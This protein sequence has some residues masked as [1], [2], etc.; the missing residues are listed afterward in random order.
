MPL[1]PRRFPRALQLAELELALAALEELEA[2]DHTIGRQW[3]QARTR[4]V[5]AV[6]AERRY[7]QEVD[8]RNDWSPHQ[9]LNGVLECGVA[10]ILRNS[11]QQPQSF[12]ASMREL[13]PLS[14]K[15]SPRPGQKRFPQLWHAQRR[16]AA[17]EIAGE[18]VA[19]AHWRHYRPMSAPKQLLVHIRWQGNACTDLILTL[20][21][22]IK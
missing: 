8:L 19:A 3:Q 21:P 16:Q 20:P 6:L 5:Q 4:R 17:K 15:Q 12:S 2:R 13:Q 14:K 18:D 7:Q 11:K 10:S 1:S 9:A 22:N